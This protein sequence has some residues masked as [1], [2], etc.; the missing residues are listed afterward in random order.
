LFERKRKQVSACAKQHGELR[1][2]DREQREQ[3]NDA[4]LPSG[5]DHQSSG[6]SRPPPLAKIKSHLTN[7]IL[8][9]EHALCFVFKRTERENKEEE[10]ARRQRAMQ[11]L[12]RRE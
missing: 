6:T 11:H 5:A 2:K 4:N 9:K 1:E 10:K 7:I 3:L 12:R 8:G